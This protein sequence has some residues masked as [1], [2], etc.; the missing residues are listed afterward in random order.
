MRYRSAFAVVLLLVALTV[1]VRANAADTG[2]Q[3]VDAAWIS[4]IKA[5]DID[6]VMKCYAPDAIMWLPDAPTARGA[7]AIRAAYEGLLSANTVKDATLSEVTYRTVGKASLAWGNF[8]LT[9]VPKAGGDQV[10]MKGRFTEVAERRGGKW[11]Y[12]VD[13]ASAEPAP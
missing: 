12:I 5:N 8:S 4:A 9:L 13:H 7:K 11:V 3:I 6:A 2:A 10:V 1:T